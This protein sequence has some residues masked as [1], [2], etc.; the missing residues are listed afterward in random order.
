MSTEHDQRVIDDLARRL[1]EVLLRRGYTEEAARNEV[2][3]AVEMWSFAS[4]IDEVPM[5]LG[6]RRQV[7]LSGSFAV[8]VPRPEP[9]RAAA[10][11]CMNR[12]ELEMWTVWRARF[13]WPHLCPVVW[14]DPDGHVLVMQR[15]T[16]DATDEQIRRFESEWMDTRTLWLPD[17]EPKPEDWGHLPEDGRLVV[18]DY[19]YDI[20][21]E[22]AIA[23][24]RRE[25]E[26][27]LALRWS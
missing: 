11:R 1:R 23:Q 17:A 9:D 4:W 26:A 27:H 12:W 21:T 6:T 18:C 22:E 24:K 8:K 13:G 2:A 15:A 7:I 20:D 19:G 25:F 14:G 3:A 5:P 10:A 16:Q